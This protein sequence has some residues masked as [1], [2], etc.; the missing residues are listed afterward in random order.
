MYVKDIYIHY[1]E[2]SLS[3]P[4][5]DYLVALPRALVESEVSPMATLAIIYNIQF[6]IPQDP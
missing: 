5:T 2:H 1:I 6:P 4:G 3:R